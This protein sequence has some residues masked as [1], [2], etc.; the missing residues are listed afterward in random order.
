VLDA[1]LRG[2]PADRTGFGL[3]SVFIF[4]TSHLILN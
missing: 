2:L 3:V 4:G 1:S